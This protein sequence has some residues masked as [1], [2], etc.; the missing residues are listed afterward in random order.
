MNDMKL[1]GIRPLYIDDCSHL[2]ALTISIHTYIFLFPLAVHLKQTE[3]A[4][5]CLPWTRC[6]DTTRSC[7]LVYKNKYFFGDRD[8]KTTARGKTCHYYFLSLV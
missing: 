3:I 6:K 2:Y 8:T 4:A 5:E 7:L 1:N